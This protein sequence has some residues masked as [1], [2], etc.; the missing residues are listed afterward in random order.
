MKRLVVTGLPCPPETWEK[1]LGSRKNQRILPLV[2]VFENT[3]S[4]DLR[5]M[6]RYVTSQIESFAPESIICHD[7]GVPLTLMALF[8][9]N[10][11]GVGRGMKITVFNGAFRKVDVFKANHPFRIQ[12]M[13]YERAVK[14]VL[15]AG[16]HIDK[17]LKNH[18]P[19]IRAM[20]RLIILYSLT[21]KLA[22]LFKVENVI[23]FNFRTPLKTS[24]QIIASRNDPYIPYEAIDQL[25]RDFA[26]KRFYEIDYGHFPYTLSREKFVPLIDEFEKEP[27]SFYH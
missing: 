24:V 6:S 12:Y 7:L 22:D 19:K 5:E 4:S 3:Q 14:E 27:S 1:F 10:R 23:G 18:L 26:V 21:E 16:G 2:E 25:R 17:R 15:S 13:S 11:K 8:R 9:L 20:Y